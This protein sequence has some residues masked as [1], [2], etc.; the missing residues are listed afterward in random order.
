MSINDFCLHQGVAY[1]EFNKLFSKTHRSVVPVQIDGCPVTE[2]ENQPAVP[3]NPCD[4][5]SS[6]ETSRFVLFL[7]EQLE[8]IKEEL[9]NSTAEQKRLNALVLSLTE[10]LHTTQQ[11][12]AE[13]ARIIENLMS[14]AR[15][16]KKNR[17]GSSSQKGTGKTQDTPGRDDNKDGFGI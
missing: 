12:N 5:M 11:K 4:G 3:Y 7:M 13:Q 17:F 2:V 8:S 1:N 16:S 14:S 15:V 6:E 9:R 10:Q